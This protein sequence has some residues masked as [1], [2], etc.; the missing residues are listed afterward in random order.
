MKKRNVLASIAMGVA[1]ALPSVSLNAEPYLNLGFFPEVP[2]YSSVLG[3]S[4]ELNTGIS[5]S[6]GSEKEMLDKPIK[7]LLPYISLSKEI[8]IL[9]L[10]IRSNT[11]PDFISLEKRAEVRSNALETGIYPSDKIFSSSIIA[12]GRL[13]FPEGK[14]PEYTGRLE[15][16][17]GSPMIDDF[18]SDGNKLLLNAG[19]NSN[20]YLNFQEAGNKS[21]YSLSDVFNEESRNFFGEVYIVVKSP[22]SNQMV[23]VKSGLDNLFDSL[24]KTANFNLSTAL[25]FPL[26]F[27]DKGLLGISKISP[28]ISAGIKMALDSR[29]DSEF[30]EA[31]IKISGP[32][33]KAILGYLHTELETGKGFYTSSGLKFDL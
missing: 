5:V 25:E 15:L 24:K 7:E 29:W 11:I 33:G 27:S 18:L 22:Y 6:Q 10:D 26:I 12:S 19:V 3:D 28:Y 21:I 14:D 4:D 1:L 9:S 2:L 23:I 32:S 16:F 20:G 17:A 13:K 8:P 31:G 30:G